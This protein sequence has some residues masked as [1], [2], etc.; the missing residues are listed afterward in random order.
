MAMLPDIYCTVTNRMKGKIGFGIYPGFGNF[1]ADFWQL[2]R[3][4]MQVQEF[5][6]L[7]EALS[8]DLRVTLQR[9]F[10]V[11][12]ARNRVKILEQKMKFLLSRTLTE[13]S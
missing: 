9:D 8:L 3:R 4:Y 5:T 2:S 11:D 6:R 13:L 12:S 7:G 10:Y 1:Y